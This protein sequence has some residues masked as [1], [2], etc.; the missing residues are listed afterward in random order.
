VSGA[1]AMRERVTIEIDSESIAA[2]K[3]AG[4]DLSELLVHALRR[5]L[6]HLHA[7]ER[8]KAAQEWYEENKEAIDSYNKLVAEHGLFSDPFRKF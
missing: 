3:E 5:R 2:A 4:I 7:E 6:P 8:Q 1:S